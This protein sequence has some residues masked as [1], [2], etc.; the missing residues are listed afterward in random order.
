M[1]LFGSTKQQDLAIEMLEESFVRMTRDVDDLKSAN[2]RLQLEWAETYDKVS[3]QMSRM[4]RRKDLV[5][6]PP[7]GPGEDLEADGT[8]VGVDPVSRS[9]LRR[10]GMRAIEK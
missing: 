1:R 2:K 7:A 10:R 9:I 6:P 3:H 5:P 8:E 4:A